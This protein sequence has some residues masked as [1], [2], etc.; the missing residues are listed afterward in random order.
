[1]QEDTQ[2]V[3][4]M[5]VRLAKI[6]PGAC[7]LIFTENRAHETSGATGLIG[8]EPLGLRSVYAPAPADGRPQ[9]HYHSQLL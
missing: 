3:E 8:R 7:R 4:L 1:M 6:V 2:S 5:S 9:Y